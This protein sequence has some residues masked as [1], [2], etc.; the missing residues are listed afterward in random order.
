MEWEKLKEREQELIKITLKNKIKPDDILEGFLK[1]EFHAHLW[2]D[3]D[4]LWEEVSSLLQSQRK[5]FVEMVKEKMK[6]VDLCNIHITMHY[7]S[8]CEKCEVR[9]KVLRTLEDIKN[10][11]Q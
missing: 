10:K 8:N 9:Q 5:E 7:P 6:E 2:V 4:K 11:I 3:T 1:G